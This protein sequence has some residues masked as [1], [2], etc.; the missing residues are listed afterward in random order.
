MTTMFTLMMTE[1]AHFSDD[2]TQYYDMSY[3][4]ASELHIK[5]FISGTTPNRGGMFEPS[6]FQVYSS[7]LD[8]M[9]SYR[10][11]PSWI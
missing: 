4:L 7:I 6:I 11:Q 1:I 2:S 10:W 9:G 8:P 5:Q 3:Q